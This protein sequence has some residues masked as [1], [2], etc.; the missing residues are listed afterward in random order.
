MAELLR[1][2]ATTLHAELTA[3]PASALG[4]HPAPG[5][6]CVKEVMGHLIEAERRGFAGRIRVILSEREPALA[7]WDQAGVAR[8]RRD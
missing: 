2:A 5:E 7:T 1:S 3:L 6:W 8:E 4:W